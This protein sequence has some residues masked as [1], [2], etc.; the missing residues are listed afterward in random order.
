MLIKAMGLGF[1]FYV[2]QDSFTNRVTLWN[3]P[4]SFKMKVSRGICNPTQYCT[5]A[6]CNY[7]LFTFSNKHRMYKSTVVKNFK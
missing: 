5:Y 3:G 6:L 4:C 7:F 1:S 2:F